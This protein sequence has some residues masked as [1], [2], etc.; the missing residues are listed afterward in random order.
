MEQFRRFKFAFNYCD[1]MR[2]VSE[3]EQFFWAIQCFKKL[4]NVNYNDQ[5]VKNFLMQ[6][7]VKALHLG[8]IYCRR[9]EHELI[10]ECEHCFLFDNAR[11]ILFNSSMLARCFIVG[12]CDPFETTIYTF[13]SACPK[14]CY[15]SKSLK[16]IENIDNWAP[17]DSGVVLDYLKLYT[18][19]NS[20]IH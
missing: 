19:F 9:V 18:V 20:I 13:R 16:N 3:P 4:N 7:S 6:F 12:F 8:M 10:C 17:D 14:T 1:K 11:L 5:K 15:K 2:K